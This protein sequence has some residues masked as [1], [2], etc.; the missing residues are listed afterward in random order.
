MSD[1]ITVTESLA[2]GLKNRFFTEM[3]NGADLAEKTFV[4]KNDRLKDRNGFAVFE[5][6]Y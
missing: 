6:R 2:N 4:D 1:Q 3:T 5:I